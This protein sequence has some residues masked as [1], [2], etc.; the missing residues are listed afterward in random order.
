MRSW[1]LLL[2][3]FPAVACASPDQAAEQPSIEEGYAVMDD[4]TRLYYEIVGEGE[5]VVVVPMAMY[6]TEALAPLA[7]GRRIVFY[8]PRNRGKSD[9]AD[10]TTVSLDRQLLDLDQLRAGLGIEKMALIGWSGL[11]MEM[12]AYTVRHP[13]RVTRLVQVAAVPPS[14]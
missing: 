3:L 10:L 9:A 8:D 12:A 13:E 2:T 6:L 7:E 5:P 14:A 11:G 4:G 1:A